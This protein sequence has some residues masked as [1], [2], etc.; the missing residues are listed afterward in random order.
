[1]ANKERRTF[2]VRQLPDYVKERNL[3]KLLQNLLSYD[4]TSDQ[5]DIFSLAPSIDSFGKQPTQVATVRFET[6]PAALPEGRNNWVFPKEASNLPYNILIDTHF[7]GLT[8]LN[9]V[10]EDKHKTE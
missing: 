3:P 4:G 2:R 5:I 7:L 8:V 9:H 10:E 1:M 6:T